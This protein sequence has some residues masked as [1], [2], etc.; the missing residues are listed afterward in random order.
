MSKALQL[1]SPPCSKPGHQG[2]LIQVT[3]VL[4]AGS[5]ERSR[6]E[7][8]ISFKNNSKATPADTLSALPGN[9]DTQQPFRRNNRKG[10]GKVGAI[11]G[12]NIIHPKAFTS[13]VL[14]RILKITPVQRQGL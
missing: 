2:A 6:P 14:N 10:C 9:N 3:M 12:N 1:R 7:R 5:P 13:G 8:G 4:W 11:T